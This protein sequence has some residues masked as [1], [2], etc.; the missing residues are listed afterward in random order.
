[1]TQP[2]SL[3]MPKPQF[4][5][6]LLLFDIS[7]ALGQIVFEKALPYTEVMLG[8]QSISGE[9]YF[10]LSDD[11]LNK[12]D[13]YGKFID[14]VA[15]S[16]H[17][18]IAVTGNEIVLAGERNGGLTITRFDYDL[19][20]VSDWFFGYSRS[21][22][23]IYIEPVLSGG[24][25]VFLSRTIIP[26]GTYQDLR[27]FALFINDDGVKVWDNQLP[28]SLSCE[29]AAIVPADENN[30]F[31]LLANEFEYTTTTKYIGRVTKVDL[32]GNFSTDETLN[33]VILISGHI[34]PT[35]I[36]VLARESTQL[37]VYKLDES[38]H[39][40]D[41]TIVAQSVDF[42]H[43]LPEH[44]TL[45]EED[46]L[47][48][49]G[50]TT[51]VQLPAGFFI[52]RTNENYQLTDTV[53]FN[54]GLPGSKMNGFIKTTDNGYCMF[55]VVYPQRQTTP[56]YPTAFVMKMDSTYSTGY[57]PSFTISNIPLGLSADIPMYWM[58][59]DN[60]GDLDMLTINYLAM[61][62]FKNNGNG[63]SFTEITNVFPPV[64][65]GTAISIADYDNDGFEDVYVQRG[66]GWAETN[67]LFRNQGNGTFQSI[68][69]TGLTDDASILSPCT[70]LDFNAD[71]YMDLFSPGRLYV[72]D[73]LGK[74]KRIFEDEI[75]AGNVWMDVNGD[76]Y[77]ELLAIGSFIEEHIYLND[78]GRNL[79][80]TPLSNFF[81]PHEYLP[82][83]GTLYDWDVVTY[84]KENKPT[85][86]IA[87]GTNWD[88]MYNMKL[89]G[90]Y[91]KEPMAQDIVFDNEPKNFVQV[92]FDNNSYQDLFFNGSGSSST[93]LY[94]LLFNRADGPAGYSFMRELPEA[95]RLFQSFSWIDLNE[96]GT[97]D[98]IGTSGS[99][100]QVLTSTPTSNNWIAIKLEGVSSSPSGEGA[101]IKVKVNNHWQTKVIRSTAAHNRTYEREAHFGIG[102]NVKADSVIVHWPSGCIQSMIAVPANQRHTLRENCS[103]ENPILEWTEN[104]CKG[105]SVEV[106][107]LN[108]GELFS[109]FT[110]TT[111]E[112]PLGE[113]GKSLFIDTLTRS[114]ILYVANADSSILSRRIPVPIQVY[115]KPNFILE[116]DSINSTTYQFSPS[117]HSGIK[118]YEW[119]INGEIVSS[120]PISEVELSESQLYTICLE[121]SNPGCETIVCD[122]V[123][124]LVTSLNQENELTFDIFPNPAMRYLQ[125]K[126]RG[127][128]FFNVKLLAPD[129]T[130][131]FNELN[132]SESNIL[133]ENLP[134]GTY[135]L[136]IEQSLKKKFSFKIIKL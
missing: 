113:S 40:I 9:Y 86:I 79:I 76:G 100:L 101:I 33:D 43:T 119:S 55:G 68:T 134:A 128:E 120:E 136:I 48:V 47:S 22:N 90:L 118:S 24:Y 73:G 72:N 112:V 25:L 106:V 16:G 127:E 104:V 49:M 58:D 13:Q 15:T 62:L 85:S 63:E 34:K 125:I 27:L 56:P 19:N 28:G 92:D 59:Y 93:E 122:E 69:D 67:I 81:M 32:T 61:R 115:E 94:E 6:L 5:A 17:Y 4:F 109:W 117:S 77:R 107:V 60:D 44:V 10:F 39:V 88:F 84:D 105:E 66:Y 7:A 95:K 45:N 121:A 97:L 54:R 80:R 111:S 42:N 12:Y 124:L 129:G 2:A 53:L 116:I 46:G 14:K 123:F 132:K 52:L 37:S 82:G 1:M 75:T 131:V 108:D 64:T 133:M 74:F 103:G 114:T 91:E 126:H 65:N 50:R 102:N 96:D 11:Y 21:F 30:Q 70:W 8:G 36:D 35:G 83:I 3:Y 99:D 41:K 23:K 18:D 98:L 57:R 110:S 89:N 26:A 71:G 29:A 78:H 31:Y 38:A 51:G 87:L 130:C 135:F 20:L